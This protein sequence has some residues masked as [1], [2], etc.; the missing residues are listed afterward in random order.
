MFAMLDPT[1][2]LIAMA[3]EPDS[4]A[5]R[6]TNNSGV[7]VAKDTTVIPITNFEMR[8][9]NDRATEALT[10][11]SPPTTS[12]TKPSITQTTLIK[13]IFFAKIARFI[14]K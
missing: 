12:K 7:E 3:G 11:N 1:T 2:L 4:A 8:N 6:L 13:N 9:L 5:F 14:S 10:K